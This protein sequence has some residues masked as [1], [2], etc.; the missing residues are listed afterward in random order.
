MKR[1]ASDSVARF[2]KSLKIL[3]GFFWWLFSGRCLLGTSLRYTLSPRR[4][5]VFE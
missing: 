1:S 4:N 2:G 5:G 3:H